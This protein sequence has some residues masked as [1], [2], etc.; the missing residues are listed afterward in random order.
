MVTQ[1]EAELEMDFFVK[2]WYFSMLGSFVPLKSM[3]Y[4]IDKFIRKGFRGVN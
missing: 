2:S 4:I 1:R 3:P